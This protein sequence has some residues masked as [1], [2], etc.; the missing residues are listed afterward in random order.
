MIASLSLA[1][2]M[3]RSRRSV[4]FTLECSGNSFPPDESV[5]ARSLAVA[6]HSERDG[7]YCVRTLRLIQLAHERAPNDV[8]PFSVERRR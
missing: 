8:S 1:D 2:L 4:D 7:N 6:Q 5:A 3:S